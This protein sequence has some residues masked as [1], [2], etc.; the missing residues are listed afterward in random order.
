M[1][2]Y[3]SYQLSQAGRPKFAAEQRAADARSGELAAAISRPIV[4]ASARI[5]AGLRGS[6]GIKP[7][8]YAPLRARDIA[9]PVECASR[10]TA[11]PKASVGS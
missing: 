6:T 8:H 5:R 11:R 7:R 3:Q 1:L 10:D 2:P 4:A 9:A